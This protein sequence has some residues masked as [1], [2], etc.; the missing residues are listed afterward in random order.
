[1][2][3]GRISMLNRKHLARIPALLEFVGQNASMAKYVA[4]A[5]GRAF[6][7]NH[8]R[9]MRRLQSGNTP[10][11]H[12]VVRDPVQPDLAVRP[13]ARTSPFDRMEKVERLPFRENIKVARRTAGA[14][15]VDANNPIAPPPPNSGITVSPRQPPV[16][17]ACQ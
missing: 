10:L 4:I 6:P 3:R 5:V 12:G 14:P 16:A 9:K 1:M 17:G 7:W 8:R 15:R 2:R 13:I 11:I